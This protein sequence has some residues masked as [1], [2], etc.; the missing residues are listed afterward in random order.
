M[1][2]EHT[3]IVNLARESGLTKFD[4]CP[5]GGGIPGMSFTEIVESMI[6]SR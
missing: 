2:I 3:M 5:G 6:Q 4:V 1:N